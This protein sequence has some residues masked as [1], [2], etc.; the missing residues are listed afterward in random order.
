MIEGLSFSIEDLAHRRLAIAKDTLD[1]YN[2]VILKKNK[3]TEEIYDIIR[4]SKDG[5]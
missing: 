3:F 1:A 2:E 5:C 4:N